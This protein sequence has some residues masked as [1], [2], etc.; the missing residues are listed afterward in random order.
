[1]LVGAND[2]VREVDGKGGQ[3]EGEVADDDNVAICR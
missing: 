2:T 1:M 3:G